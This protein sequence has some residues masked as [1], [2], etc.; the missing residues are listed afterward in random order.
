[1]IITIKNGI[2]NLVGSITILLAMS[3]SALAADEIVSVEA[4]D[5]NNKVMGLIEEYLTPFG[6]MVIFVML[7]IV[8][9]KLLITS[10]KPQARAEVM[11]SFPYIIIGGMVIGGAALIAG[12]I[13]GAGT[14][15]N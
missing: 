14:S 12:F 1:M 4:A 7:I 13:I 3:T 5:M 2:K 8:G 15:L 9:F 10:G 11:Q 6:G